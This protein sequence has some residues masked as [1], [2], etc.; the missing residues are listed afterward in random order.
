MPV[1]LTRK[2]LPPAVLLFSLFIGIAA[3]SAGHVGTGG[4]GHELNQV[5]CGN[6]YASNCDS[7][8]NGRIDNADDS[9]KVGGYAIGDLCRKDGTNCPADATGTLSCTSR[10]I[11]LT[12]KGTQTCAAN[13]EMCVIVRKDSGHTVLSCGQIINDDDDRYYAECCKVA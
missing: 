13:S 7:N 1:V 3:V 11:A 5:G 4:V 2:H 10:T 12:K 9:T 6:S 8:S